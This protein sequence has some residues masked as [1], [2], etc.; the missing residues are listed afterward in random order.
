MQKFEKANFNIANYDE[1]DNY[2]KFVIEPLER[3]FGTTLGNSLRRVL[4]SSLPGSAVYAIKVQGAIHEFSAVDGVVED[5]T[6]IILNLKKLV[7]DVDS[8]ESATM[9]IDVEGPATVTGADIQCPSEVTMISNDM[10]I[11]HVAQG[12]HLYMELYAKKDRGYVSADQNKKEINTIGI[13]PT[14]SIYSPVEKV[15]Y[16]VEPTRVGE[17]A[18]YDQLTL[19]IE[20]NGALKPYEAIS[21]AAKILVEHLNMFVELTDMAVNMEVMSEAQSDTTNKV[22]DM[23]IEELDLSVRSYNCL[24]RAGIQTVQDLAAKSEDDM[25]KVRN[26]GKKSLKEVKEKLVELGLG[27]KPID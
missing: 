21:L 17:S 6:S 19:E 22:L 5:V 27:F 25:I 3:G 9:I 20:T 8:D 2:G 16:A 13:I 14:D 11:A 23:T 10:E 12:A 15:S 26:L 1:T 24:K 7:F 18:K 4:L